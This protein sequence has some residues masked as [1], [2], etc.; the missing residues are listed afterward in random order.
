VRQVVATHEG[1]TFAVACSVEAMDLSRSTVTEPPGADALLSPYL[2]GE[3]GAKLRAQLAKLHPDASPSEIEDAIQ[4]AC[5]R[6]MSKTDGITEQG[7]VYTWL[8]TTAHRE[9]LLEDEHRKRLVVVNPAKTEAFEAYELDPEAEAIAHEDEAELEALVREVA[10]L[11]SPRKRDVLALYGAGFKRPEIASRLGVSERVVKR[12]LVEIM[13]EARAAIA[14]KAGGGCE[15][16]EPLVL[17]FAY[18]LASSGEAEQAHRHMASCRRCEVLWERLDA[19]REKVGALLPVSAVEQANPGFLERLAHRTVDGFATVK[20]HVL[21]GASQV[22]QQAVA[23]AT[24][25]YRPIDPTPFAGAK[26][27]PM[28]LAI[29]SCLTIAGGGAAYC[30]QNH[31]DPIGAATGFIAGTQSPSNPESSSSPD[32]PESTAIVPPAPSPVSEETP[33]AEEAAPPPNES[34]PEPKPEPEPPP[35]EASFEPSSPNYPASEST[36]TESYESESAPAAAS[37]PAPA[38]GGGTPQFGG[39]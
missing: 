35:P 28:A 21:G 33:P 10:A 15:R 37:T 13:D 8:R 9:L 7:Q 22:K 11:L 23:S 17:R 20:Q 32:A 29:V 24:A 12:D 31:V 34:E 27:G 14:R 26:P 36:E 5:D 3:R 1:S 19:W 16:G 6:F 38:S 25:S 4:T 18:G 30:A 2:T 39:P